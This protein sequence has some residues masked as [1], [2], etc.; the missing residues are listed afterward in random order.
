MLSIYRTALF[1]RTT[2]AKDKQPRQRKGKIFRNG[3]WWTPN[4]PMKSDNPRKKY[5]V[6]A[7]KGDRVKLIRYGDPNMKDYTQ[8]KDKKRRASYRA[9]AKGILNKSGQPAY[10]DFFSPARWSMRKWSRS[11]SG[12]IHL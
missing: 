6:L 1:A 12:I 3:R 5:M 10:K 11:K 2:G 8:H 9:R 7:K 4:K